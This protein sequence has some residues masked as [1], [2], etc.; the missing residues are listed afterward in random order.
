MFTGAVTSSVCCLV[1]LLNFPKQANASNKQR[2]CNNVTASSRQSSGMG[3]C[4][5]HLMRHE[6][7]SE[8]LHSVF[9]KLLDNSSRTASDGERV[10]LNSMVMS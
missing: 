2:D 7:H 9:Q 8:F 3:K 4:S 6:M 1:S 5:N 10:W